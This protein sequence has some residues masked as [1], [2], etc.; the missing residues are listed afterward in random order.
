PGSQQLYLNVFPTYVSQAVQGLDSMLRV[1]SGCFEQTTANAWPN[2]LVTDYM[3]QTDQITPDVLLKAESLMSAGY[4]RLLSFEHPGGGFSCCGTQDSGPF[5]SVTAFGLLEFHDMA[6]VHIVDEAMLQRT[7]DY[8]LAQQESDGSWPGDTSE[9]FSFHTSGLRNTAFTLMAIGA[10]EY[11]GPETELGVEYLKSQLQDD[12]GLDSYTLALVANALAGVAPS[13]PL[14]TQLLD[15]LADMAVEDP[16]DDTLLSWDTAGT[17][18]TFYGYGN[19]A[20]ITTTALAVHAML[21]FGGYTDHVTR[22][23]NKLAASKDSLGNFGSTQATVW[24]LKTLLLAATK[25]TAPAIGEF[26]VEVDG[27]PTHTLSL[28]EEQSDVMTTIDL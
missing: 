2:V 28:T 24:A 19:D 13:D 25:G 5:L 16:N 23:L 22:G 15:A 10:A 26:V 8:L 9:F 1:P 14:L 21:L 12:T 18:T 11:T 20:E 17:Q 3:K 6:K 27:E 4:Q 7:L